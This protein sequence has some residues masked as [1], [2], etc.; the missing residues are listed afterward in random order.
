MQLSL[1]SL[2]LQKVEPERDRER[3]GGGRI[4]AVERDEKMQRNG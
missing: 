1:R 4:P 3:D 2:G